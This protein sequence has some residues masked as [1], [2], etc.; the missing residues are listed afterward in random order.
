MESV[1]IW[2]SVIDSEHKQRTGRRSETVLTRNLRITGVLTFLQ[3]VAG[4][5]I[6]GVPPKRV[7]PYANPI[8][9]LAA[10]AHI[11]TKAF[12]MGLYGFLVAAPLSHYL[13]G[14]LQKFFAGKTGAGAKIAQI[15][16][17]NLLIAPI[18]TVGMS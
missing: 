10:R 3:E 14:L 11:N 5:H 9:Q 17:S 4:S 7:S 8:F 15:L 12:K 2:T 13:N 16:A 1:N 6:A 18:Q